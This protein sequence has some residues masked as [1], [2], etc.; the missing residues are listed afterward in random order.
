M[1]PPERLGADGENKLR[2][3]L[4]DVQFA[5]SKLKLDLDVRKRL[6]PKWKGTHEDFARLL[7]KR[8]A[9]DVALLLD[10][11]KALKLERDL[12]EQAMQEFLDDKAVAEDD[13]P[14]EYDWTDCVPI[15][16]IKSHHHRYKHDG[17][18]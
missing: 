17:N 3:R 10:E 6:F 9:D 8:Y 1:K 12:S 4:K 16:D 5:L 13:T 14:E 18:S 2:E 11:I 7:L 15:K